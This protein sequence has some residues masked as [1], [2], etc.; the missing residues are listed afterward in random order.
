MFDQKSELEKF[1]KKMLDEIDDLVEVD[2]I[3]KKDWKDINMR[4]QWFLDGLKG[5]QIFENGNYSHAF[6]EEIEEDVDLT[7]R[8]ADKDIG[9]KF[10][11]GDLEKYRYIYYKRIIRI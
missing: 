1:F 6:G 3:L 4:F 7:L 8:F 2:E 5:Y 11:K 10:L 9:L